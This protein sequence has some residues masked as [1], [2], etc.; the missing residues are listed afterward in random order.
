M[1]RTTSYANKLIV[2]DRI[3][4]SKKF[5]SKDCGFPE[6]FEGFGGFRELREACGKNFHLISCKFTSMVTS[7]DKKTKNVNE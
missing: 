1:A 3:G 5:V 7:Y 6:V 2:V 4:F